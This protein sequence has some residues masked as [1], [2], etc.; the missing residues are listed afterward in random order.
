MPAMPQFF[1][2]LA[3]KIKSIFGSH[4]QS[5]KSRFSIIKNSLIPPKRGKV[6]DPYEDLCNVTDV[7]DLDSTATFATEVEKLDATFS[8]SERPR[9]DRD[10]P[11][12]DLESTLPR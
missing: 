5:R 7:Y 11:A 2:H 9:N 8:T 1:R 4:D 12:R 3:L 10:H 6:P